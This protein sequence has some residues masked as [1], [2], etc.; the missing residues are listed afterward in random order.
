MGPFPPLDSEIP[1]TV[2]AIAHAHS[3]AGTDGS[4]SLFGNNL[5]AH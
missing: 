4:V 3:E 5:S 1:F 2:S